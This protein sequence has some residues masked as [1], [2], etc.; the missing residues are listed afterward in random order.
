MAWGSGRSGKS[1][2]SRAYMPSLDRKSGIPQETDTCG[3][4]RATNQ[5]LT[6]WTHTQSASDSKHHKHTPAPVSTS[7]FFLSFRS[8]T[9]SS[10]VLMSLRFFL[11][12]GSEMLMMICHSVMSSRSGGRSVSGSMSFKMALGSVPLMMCCWMNRYEPK[13]K[14]SF[15]LIHT[16]QKFAQHILWIVHYRRD[17]I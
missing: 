13:R 2:A 12:G 5:Y 6:D 4:T 9:T 11:L 1:T 10:N 8:R 15:R 7:I 3:G 16:T 17:L 14:P